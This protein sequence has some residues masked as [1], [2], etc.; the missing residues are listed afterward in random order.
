MEIQP[1][2]CRGDQF[3]VFIGRTG[4]LGIWCWELTHLK[5]PRCWERLRAGGEGDYRGWDG[6]TASLTQW[7][8]VW[9]DSGSWWWAGKPGM[10]W[11]MGLQRV[12]HDWA[13][14]LKWTELRTQNCRNY[15]PQLCLRVLICPSLY[16]WKVCLWDLNG[17]LYDPKA[18]RASIQH[19]C[20]ALLIFPQLIFGFM[21]IIH[22]IQS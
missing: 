21:K 3:L 13:T 15:G 5:R 7:T 22:R 14:E 17:A 19:S 10:L 2:H 9:V 6:W 20:S 16:S 12:G 8:W 4:T 11:F 18:C 1:V